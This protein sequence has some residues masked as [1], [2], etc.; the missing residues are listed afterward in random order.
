MQN[1]YLYYQKQS[2]K[3]T[4]EWGASDDYKNH[5]HIYT[6]EMVPPPDDVYRV[7]KVESRYFNYK[8]RNTTHPD[9]ANWD[10]EDRERHQVTLQ[11]G[12]IATYVWFKFI[13]QPA[14]KTAQQNWPEVYTTEYLATLQSRIEALHA[15]V[16]VH[17]KVNPSEPVFINYAH[18][19]GTGELDPHLAKVDPGQLVVPPQ[20]MELGY[21]P[22][23][24]SVYHPDE[25]SF[26][27]SGF[28]ET[29][30]PECANAAWTDTYHPHIP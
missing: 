22:V 12:S 20:G 7:P 15:K 16:A 26:N 27:G 23:I 13:E 3:W 11:N 9:F 8:E 30:D 10:I 19:G 6:S 29:P 18:G 28:F 5:P 21:V 24:I 4:V 17:S 14:M 25:R 1:G 2:E